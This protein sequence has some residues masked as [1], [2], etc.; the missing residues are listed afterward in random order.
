[1]FHPNFLSKLSFKTFTCVLL[2][3]AGLSCKFIEA[4]SDKP[5]NLS[6]HIH[7]LLESHSL[8]NA[9]CGI[10][11]VSIRK[12]KSVF[13]YR[14]DD[15][16]RVA[17]N[18]K[19]VTT[20]AALD[21]LGPDFKYKTKIK[22]RG[23]I[24]PSGVLK[25]D[26]VIVGSGDP[27]ISGRFFNGNITAIPQNWAFTIKDRGIHTITGDIVADDR[28]FD[29]IY[30]NPNWPVD[31]FSEWYCAQ[32]S[33]LS[34]NDNCADIT[35]LPD[36]ING[37]IVKLLIEP[38]TSYFAIFNK[39]VY[40]INK[41]EHGYSIQ[42]EPGTNRI[43]ING[44]FWVNRKPEKNWVNINNPSLYFAT[45]FKETLEGSGVNILGNVRLIDE[46]DSVDDNFE[47]IA[48]S[49]S[50]MEQTVI[51]TNKNSQNFYAEQILKTLGY[52]IKGHGSSDTG[53]EVLHDFLNKLGFNPDEFIIEDGCGLSKGNK[54]SPRI[55]TTLLAYMYRHPCGKV[56]YD[57]L[58][59]S[60]VDGG[61]QNR[62]TSPQYENRIH[63]KTGF[64]AKTSALSGYIDMPDGD[65]LAFSILINDFNNLK[66]VLK[67]QDDICKTI[68]DCYN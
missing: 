9:C 39:C 23:L 19:L 17:S 41:K 15:M 2:F 33:G 21:F 30:T 25:G 37:T 56:L 46:S 62:M 8:K 7:A 20:S 36:K 49:T 64:I 61:L 54:L 1:M 12:N 47:T 44:K 29:R 3:F 27:N 4:S 22:S 65:T 40:T 26:L 32:T 42:R 11:I 51:V 58:P 57:S 13:M 68:V 16:F 67:I 59:S 63:A 28:V 60:A 31:Q 34:F 43:F 48:E 18:M 45:V 52:H 50:T 24:K 35:L 6:A 55:L 5:C 53:I 10:S 14:E 66:D 38:Y